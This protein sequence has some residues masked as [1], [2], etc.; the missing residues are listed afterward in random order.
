VPAARTIAAPRR[1]RRAL[2][3]AVLAGGAS[4]RMGEPKAT[5]EL[6]GRTLLARTVAAVAAAGL[7]PVV[8]AKPTSPLP[9]VECRVLAEPAEPLHPLCG[10]VTALAAGAGRG[11]V[12]VAC[13]MPLVPPKLLGWLAG[14]DPEPAVVC[15]VA[16]RLE[17]LLARYEPESAAALAAAL[18]GGDSMRAAVAA[19]APRVIGEAELRR[20][21]D[22][23]RIAFNVNSPAD[24]VR[25][26]ALLA[27]G[28]GRWRPLR[29]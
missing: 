26:H 9:P 21:G 25:A 7:E 5:V 6:A 4:R 14:L 11:V 3:G 24:L 16:G 10:I 28:T 15:E 29:R 13:D 2:L 19:L 8:V 1:P 20:F 23:A 17:P 12:V 22:P 18:D 27:E